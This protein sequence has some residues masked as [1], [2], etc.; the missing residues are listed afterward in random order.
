MIL[1]VTLNAAVDRAYQVPHFALDRIHRTGTWRTY[2]G[3]K[4]INVARVY[5]TLGGTVRTT[6]FL[7]GHNGQIIA[8]ALAQEHIPTDFVP[9]QEE[10]RLCLAILDPVQ[11]TQTEVNEVGPHITASEIKRLEAEF[12][13]IIEQQEFDYVVF[14]GSLPPGVPADIYAVLIREAN[15]AGV[16]TV[17]DTS[18]AA[19]SAGLTA[20]PQTVKP[21]VH[22]L[23]GVAEKPLDSQAACVAVCRE[24]LAK[25]IQ[26]I[27]V[28]FGAAGCLC[29]TEAGVWRAVPPRVDV[30]SAVGSGDSFLAAFLWAQAQGEDLLNAL[31]LA[32]GAG[33]ANAMVDGAG[34]CTAKS[35]HSL[36]NQ[37]TVE[38]W[39]ISDREISSGTALYQE[40][41]TGNE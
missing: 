15:R 9:V 1:T 34:F 32:T 41:G 40:S 37:V 17:L 29:I 19:L 18:G 30:I 33:A 10:S 5:Q 26:T 24:W 16:A 8:D 7:G 12:C 39:N 21:N 35:I 2:A 25:G 28:T 6:G 31:R 38:E 20:L 14:S 11:K 22:E 4:G 23:A 36:A 27:C 13:R 3:G